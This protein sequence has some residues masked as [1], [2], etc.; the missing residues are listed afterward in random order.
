MSRISDIVA[1]SGYCH[2]NAP[3]VNHNIDLIKILC[4]PLEAGYL[5]VAI[6]VRKLIMQIDTLLSAGTLPGLIRNTVEGPRV[7]AALKLLTKVDS[8]SLKQAT[9]REVLYLHA[10]MQRTSRAIRKTSHV[11]TKQLEDQ[12]MAKLVSYRRV[13]NGVVV[14]GWK[15]FEGVVVEDEAVGGSDGGDND[16]EPSKKD[17]EKATLLAALAKLYTNMEREKAGRD[18]NSD[19][20]TYKPVPTPVS[21]W[22]GQVS[23]GEGGGWHAE[24][25]RVQGTTST[26]SEHVGEG[27]QDE[28]EP[29]S[30]N[31]GH[32]E[33][34]K[35]NDIEFCG[36]RSQLQKPLRTIDKQEDKKA[37]K[38]AEKGFAV[39]Q[40]R[41]E[42][43]RERS[44]AMSPF[45]PASA[46]NTSSRSDCL[47]VDDV[48]GVDRSQDDGGG[49]NG[50]EENFK[51][52]KR[53]RFKTKAEG[54]MDN[55]DAGEH[56]LYP[57]AILGPDRRDAQEA[58]PPKPR[59][60]RSG[61]KKEK[62]QRPVRD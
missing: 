1:P 38:L 29:S 24:K 27:A 30:S 18:E 37:K 32:E 16:E 43:A 5:V 2:G 17:R 41:S 51:V 25:D 8:F 31:A 61:T 52:K 19:K 47:G 62:R 44:T 33:E 50:K 11:T 39:E 59:N 7:S 46:S 58:G 9:S 55:V 54:G 13:T 48:L 23:A 12:V 3:M 45:T 28:D 49:K 57:H 40:E 22:T 21:I 35:E 4:I 20:Q 14:E 26:N 56:T 10:E 36:R 42:N 6:C 34:Q 60:K 15:N 53:A